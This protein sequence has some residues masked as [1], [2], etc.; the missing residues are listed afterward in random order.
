ML[1]VRLRNIPMAAY[2]TLYPFFFFLILRYAL[3]K[4]AFSDK[5]CNSITTVWEDL[6]KMIIS[7]LYKFL[8]FGFLIF[9]E[10]RNMMHD[11]RRK[12]I[13]PFWLIPRFLNKDNDNKR[14]FLLTFWWVGH[15]CSSF[16]MNQEVY[17]WLLNACVNDLPVRHFRLNKEL[18]I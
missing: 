7:Y 14:V 15:T 3:K 9:G 12:I 5:T 17:G 18:E 16:L 13:Y 10:W 8:F 11:L 6:P 1:G 4:K 2:C